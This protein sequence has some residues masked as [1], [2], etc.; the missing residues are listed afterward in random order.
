MSYDPE[1]HHRRSIRLQGYDYAQAGA[2]FVTICALHRQC[3]F[4][5]IRGSIIH[6][7]PFGQVAEAEWMRTAELRPY[8]DLDAFIVKPNH[9]HG[10]IVL[11]RD[12]LD[13][14][15]G[16]ARRAPTGERF[17]APVV[18]SLPTIVRAFKGATTNR[19]NAVRNSPGAPI[20]QRNYYEHIIRNDRAL[21]R[22]RDYVAGNPSRWA[23]D[24]LHPDNPSDW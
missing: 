6:L 9:M 20:W 11:N 18:G 24:T 12:S 10:I 13:I 7:S 15:A 17:G 4:G 3:I 21:E 16:T 22:L 5:E 8:V 14:D 23:A 19:I 1:R 2:Y